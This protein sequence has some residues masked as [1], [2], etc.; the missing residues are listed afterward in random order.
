MLLST[1]RKILKRIEEKLQDAN[2]Y[3]SVGYYGL[4]LA[5]IIHFGFLL[6]F[7]YLKLYLLSA[8]NIIS[9]MIYWYCIFGI[10][11]KTLESRDD[12]RIGWLVYLE[13]VGHNAIATYYLGSGAGFQ[14]YVYLLAVIP[15]FISTYSMPI[16]LFRVVSALGIA[17]VL[18][19]ADYFQKIR[20]DDL[21][22]SQSWFFWMNLLTA[23]GALLFLFYLYVR[24]ERAY[25]MMLTE[26]YGKQEDE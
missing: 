15:F 16:Y 24:K 4:I 5:G 9:V 20:V 13:L 18:D 1:H 22:V 21:A 11:L 12:G 19:T 6:L 25:H 10:G 8:V 7:F 23:L 14:Y 17:I 26:Q 2:F 3:W